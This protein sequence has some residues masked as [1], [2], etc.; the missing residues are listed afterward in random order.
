MHQIS[1]LRPTLLDTKFRVL[2]SLL[3][4]N[5]HCCSPKLSEFTF[6]TRPIVTVQKFL[7][8]MDLAG[9][10]KG[11]TFTK[12]TYQGENNENSRNEYQQKFLDFIKSFR[13]ESEFTY[14]YFNVDQG[15]IKAKYGSKELLFRSR[16]DRFDYIR[17]GF[18]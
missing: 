7:S 10:T 12:Q 9:W 2:V 5:R 16:H 1:L 18:G 4:S 15:T 3:E 13:I 17:R 11:N 14:R 8:I 6:R